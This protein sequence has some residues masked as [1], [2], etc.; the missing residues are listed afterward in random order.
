M[1]VEGNLPVIVYRV[2]SSQIQSVFVPDTEEYDAAITIFDVYLNRC[3]I[4]LGSFVIPRYAVL[5]YYQELE[6]DLALMDC[7]LINTFAEHR[8]V[9]DI[10]NYYPDIKDLTPKTWINAWVNA[11]EGAY[12]VKGRTNSRKNNWNRMMFAK[13]RATVP[14]VVGRLLEDTYIAEQQLVIREYIPL[15]TFGYGINGVPIANEW[16]FFILDGK[17]L[18]GGFYWSIEPDLCPTIDPMAPPEGATQLAGEVAERLRDK[19]RFFVVDVAR[20]D[21]RDWIVIELN[22]GSQSGLSMIDPLVFY[23]KL[24]ARF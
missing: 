22:D 17:V 3:A 24:R 15:E 6:K 16:R 7:K 21:K 14:I 2:G 8:Y 19:I 10:A 5:P 12:V 1:T 4:P 20:T 18:V 13:D 23:K 11:P 9:A